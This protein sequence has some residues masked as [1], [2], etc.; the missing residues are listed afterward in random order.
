M[1]FD[2]EYWL[3]VLPVER[4]LEIERRAITEAT[5]YRWHQRVI[6]FCQEFGKDATIGRFMDWVNIPSEIKGD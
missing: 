1:N 3:S 5:D 2:F 4:R 6:E